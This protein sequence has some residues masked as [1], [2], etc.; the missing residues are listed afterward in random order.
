[1]IWS[2]RSMSAEI[3]G[4]IYGIARAAGALRQPPR[5]R[6]PCAPFPHGLNPALQAKLE[7]IVEPICRIVRLS[8]W[9]RDYFFRVGPWHEPP[10]ESTEDLVFRLALDAGL[11]K[12]SDFAGSDAEALGEA[13]VRRSVWKA[14]TDIVAAP[15]WGRPEVL[16]SPTEMAS[17]MK[18]LARG[19]K[20]LV[21]V[22]TLVQDTLVDWVRGHVPGQVIRE[23][24]TADRERFDDTMKELWPLLAD[25]AL[26]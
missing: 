5:A 3:F 26:Q 7:E 17:E 14:M 19:L 1:M 18:K 20:A 15:D 13:A 24:P 16:L 8:D 21:P 6:V 11:K 9:T 4:S 2:E 12:L 22:K 23:L 10:Y 25:L